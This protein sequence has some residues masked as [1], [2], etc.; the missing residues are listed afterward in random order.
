MAKQETIKGLRGF[1]TEYRL[2]V[3]EDENNIQNIDNINPQIREKLKGH[4]EYHL[5]N[6]GL[7]SV[8]SPKEKQ[9]LQ[10]N[11]HKFAYQVLR[12]A[13]N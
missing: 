4:I 1:E 11:C 7:F 10:E 13:Y 5:K 12:K 3:L 6:W 2:R 8:E 9:A